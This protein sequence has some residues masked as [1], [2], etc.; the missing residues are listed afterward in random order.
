MKKLLLLLFVFM[1]S[2][3]H[4]QETKKV[5]IDADTGNE[6]DDLYAIVRGLIEPDWEVLG[7]NATQWQASH[8][9]V[10]KSMEESYRLNQVLLSYLQM[11]GKVKSNRGAEARLYDWGNKSQTSA[12]SNF[13]IEEAQKAGNDKINVIVL[14]ALTNVASAILDE[15]SVTSKIRVYWLGTTYDFERGVMK[16]LDFNSV[17]DIQAVDVVFNSDV[18]L[19]VI[20]GNVSSQMT[21]NWKETEE[22]FRGKHDLLDFLL[23]RWYNHLDGGRRKRTIWDLSIIQAVIHP[24]YAEQVKVTTRKGKGN[25]EVWFYRDIDAER[26]REEFYNTTLDHV[27]ELQP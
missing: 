4:A 18:E 15:P 12:A 13:I 5:I 14:G 7:L 19:H 10:P 20:P 25:R 11:D 6:V 26:M 3:V 1:A 2:L 9:S 22:R 17:M 8:W 21:M 24:E 16:N 23:Q 27:K